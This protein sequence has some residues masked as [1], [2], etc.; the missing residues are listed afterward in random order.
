MVKINGKAVNAQ[1]MSLSDYLGQEGYQ[2]SR[3]AVE[4]NEMIVPKEAYDKKI[5]EDGDCIEI[6]CFVGGG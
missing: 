1:G 4:C 5:L 2:S 6:V 3:I